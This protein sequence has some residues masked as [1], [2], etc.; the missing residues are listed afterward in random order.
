MVPRSTPNQ[1]EVCFQEKGVIM[2]NPKKSYVQIAPSTLPVEAKITLSRTIVLDMTGNPL[3]ADTPVP[4]AGLSKSTDELSALHL[5]LVALRKQVLQLGSAE[6]EKSFE[7]GS[8]LT[9]L[10]HYVQVK[11]QGNPVVIRQ[12][13]MPIRKAPTPVGVLPAPSDVKASNAGGAGQVTVTWK[14]EKGARGYRVEQCAD[15]PTEAGFHVVDIAVKAVL[16][17]EGLPTGAKLWYRVRCQSA[18]G[19]GKPSEPAQVV[20][21]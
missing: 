16:L 13:G 18:A 10:G 1:T 2:N 14:P 15:P 6:K 5:Q 3:F 9:D 8:M 4:L 20:V 11:S 12:S 21:P 7:V 17:V 19:K